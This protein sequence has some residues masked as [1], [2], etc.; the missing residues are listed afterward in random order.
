MAGMAS[1]NSYKKKVAGGGVAGV[2]GER[3]DNQH[4]IERGKG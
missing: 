3:N 1:S 4:I 2:A